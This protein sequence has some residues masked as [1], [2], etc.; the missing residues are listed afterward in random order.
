M[1]RKIDKMKVW[2]VVCEYAGNNVRPSTEVYD[3]EAKAEAR[4]DELT[5]DHVYAWYK[6]RIVQ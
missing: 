3:S 6:E 4:I 5:R 2:V 1:V